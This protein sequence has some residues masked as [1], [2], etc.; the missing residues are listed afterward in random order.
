[1][2]TKISPL[3]GKPAPAERLVDVS[4]LVAAYYGQRP[5]PS[6]GR[7]IRRKS[8]GAGKAGWRFERW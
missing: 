4:K 6:V 1:M 2:S 3:A 8:S 7:N 5:D